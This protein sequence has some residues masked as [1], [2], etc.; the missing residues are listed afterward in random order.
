MYTH[1]HTHTHT[2]THTYVYTSKS[3][4][5]LFLSQH[6]D[7]DEDRLMSSVEFA[8]P[9][10]QQPP[11]QSDNTRLDD[12]SSSCS[13]FDLCDDEG[14]KSGDRTPAVVEFLSILDRSSSA[15]SLPFTERPSRESNYNAYIVTAQK[16]TLK[17]CVHARVIIVIDIMRP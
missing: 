6:E 17:R 4:L 10:L 11:Q 12:P 13:S 16:R 15:N 2:R 1:T 8:A 14:D 7:D 5:T 9:P 3:V